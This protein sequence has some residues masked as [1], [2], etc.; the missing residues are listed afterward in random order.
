MRT[1]LIAVLMAMD[2]SCQVDMFERTLHRDVPALREHQLDGP[3][4]EADLADLQ[5]DQEFQLGSRRQ[6]KHLSSMKT[7]HQN[8]TAPSRS[9]FPLDGGRVGMGVEATG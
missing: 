3:R 4:I 7:G 8:A 6:R 1:L 2:V 5:P 9:P